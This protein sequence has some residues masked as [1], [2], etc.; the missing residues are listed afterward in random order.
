MLRKRDGDT[1]EL[2]DS[3]GGAYLATLRFEGTR[4]HARLV[5]RLDDASGPSIEITLAQ[6]VPKGMKMD[7]VVEKATEIGVARIVPLITE[8]TFG[9]AALRGGKIERWRRIA[10]SAAQ[11]SGRRDVPPVE[12]PAGWDALCSRLGEFDRVLIPWELA[13]PVSLKTQL[14]A[15]LQGAA[16]IAVAIGPEGGL[17]HAEIERASAAGAVTISLGRRIL[18][19]ETAGLVAC[20]AIFYASGDL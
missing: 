20:S 6:A 11:Q 8:R 2:C 3:S 12:S 17:S 9:A 10:L 18:R 14:P 13:D 19:T 16:R 15:L 1:I 5:E 4:V 7:A